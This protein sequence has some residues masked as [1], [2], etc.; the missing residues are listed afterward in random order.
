MR[1]TGLEGTIRYLTESWLPTNFRPFPA[2]GTLILLCSRRLEETGVHLRD[3]QHP[4]KTRPSSK[5]ELSLV[6]E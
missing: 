2:V 5:V 1:R 6:Q 4:V 3:G